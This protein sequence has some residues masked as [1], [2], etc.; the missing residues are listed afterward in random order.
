LT[1]NEQSVAELA[2]GGLTNRE[3]A[4]RT[5]MSR[6]TVEAN[7]SRAHQKLGVRSRTELVGRMSGH[8]AADA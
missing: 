4:A 3:I 2:V 5:F 8:A 7:L 6:R 1:A